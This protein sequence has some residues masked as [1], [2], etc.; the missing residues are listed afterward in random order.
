MLITFTDTQDIKLMMIFYLLRLTGALPHQLWNLF[1]NFLIAHLQQSPH[2]TQHALV[3]DWDDI[4]QSLSWEHELKCMNSLIF[5][6]IPATDSLKKDWMKRPL[7]WS[8]ALPLL[9]PSKLALFKWKFLIAMLIW[10]I[11][12]KKKVCEKA[13]QVISIIFNMFWYKS[14]HISKAVVS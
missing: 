4:S 11:M 3:L 6:W 9:R 10:G 12:Q 14:L 13:T 8:P 7:C 1:S 2:R 5:P